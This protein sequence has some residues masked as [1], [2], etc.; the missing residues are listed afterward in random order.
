[1]SS[2]QGRRQLGDGLQQV[3]NASRRPSDGQRAVQ[4]FSQTTGGPLRQSTKD[5][6]ILSAIGMMGGFKMPSVGA[7]DQFSATLGLAK[8][9]KECRNPFQLALGV[10]GKQA[11]KH[12]SSQALKPRV[13][14][15]T[16]GRGRGPP[17]VGSPAR[18]DKSRRAAHQLRLEQLGTLKKEEEDAGGENDSRDY[19]EV[20][21]LT[22]HAGGDTS[23]PIHFRDEL[24]PTRRRQGHQQ[25]IML[26]KATHS[27]RRL[28]SKQGQGGAA[29]F[30]YA[31]FSTAGD[32]ELN[33]QFRVEFRKSNQRFVPGPERRWVAA[34][35]RGGRARASSSGLQMYESGLQEASS[36]VA[37]NHLAAA[38]MN[39]GSMPEDVLAG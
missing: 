29:A 38:S 34:V 39:T 2:R 32:N 27:R 10:T 17:N 1:M 14:T 19:E 36:D 7:K 6:Q 31:H 23:A 5:L 33:P 16:S 15:A 12:A 11:G 30:S 35:D 26:H 18:W 21:E 3:V 25:H 4:A 8:L 37:Q 28:L 24:G 13:K 20:T 9:E 22:G